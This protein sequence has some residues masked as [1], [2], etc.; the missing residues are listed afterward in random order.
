MR[1]GLR[2][3]LIYANVCH[4]SC[5]SCSGSTI[6]DCL[7]CYQGSLQ[8]GVCLCDESNKYTHLLTGCL[9]ECPRDYYL[10]DDSNYC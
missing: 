4:I 6:N 10:A 5:A 8:A 7:T 2:N 9:S 3:I 1:I